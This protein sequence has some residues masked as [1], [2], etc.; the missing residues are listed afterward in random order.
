M[1]KARLSPTVQV[2]DFGLRKPYPRHFF[3]WNELEISNKYRGI[4]SRLKRHTAI[5]ERTDDLHG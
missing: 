5:F 4:F 2:L 3:Q 1:P